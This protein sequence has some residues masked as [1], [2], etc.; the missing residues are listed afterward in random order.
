MHAAQ[1]PA[2]ERLARD[3]GALGR[4]VAKAYEQG[5]EQSEVCLQA[6]ARTTP[7]A[8]A[9]TEQAPRRGA[10]EG[11]GQ[12]RAGR[13]TACRSAAAGARGTPP[14]ASRRT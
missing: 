2:S 12:R 14:R 9:A 8:M 4:T 3:L 1:L 7:A 11:A 6:A 5:Q 13:A 10:A